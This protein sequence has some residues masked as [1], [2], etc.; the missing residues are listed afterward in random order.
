MRV[1]S[2]HK[3]FNRHSLLVSHYLKNVEEAL[4]VFSY[5][6]EIFHSKEVVVLFISPFEAVL[7][8]VNLKK[9]VRNL[10]CC[11]NPLNQSC[12]DFFLKKL[13]FLF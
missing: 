11:N 6:H 12:D 13:E 1:D 10:N 9:L 4:E 2:A 3:R 8:I 7:Q 5:F